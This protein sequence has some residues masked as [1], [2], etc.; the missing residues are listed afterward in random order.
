MIYIFSLYLC[1][2]TAANKHSLPDCCL[3]LSAVS[4]ALKS[5]N[6]PCH[7]NLKAGGL[8]NNC[9]MRFTL[10]SDK[11]LLCYESSFYCYTRTC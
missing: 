7:K 11:K 5:I 4:P 6:Q 8:N 2:I 1:I 3:M 9:F 10:P